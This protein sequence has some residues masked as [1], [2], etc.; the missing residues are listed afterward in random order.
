[1]QHTVRNQEYDIHGMG[2]RAPLKYHASRHDL[3]DWC[4]VLPYVFIS[5]KKEV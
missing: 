2:V 3:C 4:C 5:A 1:M